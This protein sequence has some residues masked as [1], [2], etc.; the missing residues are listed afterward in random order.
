MA[1]GQAAAVMGQ[2]DQAA[3]ATAQV[4]PAAQADRAAVATV[5][6]G[7][8]VQVHQV[9]DILR[10][11]PAPDILRLPRIAVTRR[12]SQRVVIPAVT[13]VPPLVR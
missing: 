9:A 12:V 6:V 4:G 2:A 8:A 5:Q 3:V 11:S 1:R 7:P 13:R 10:A